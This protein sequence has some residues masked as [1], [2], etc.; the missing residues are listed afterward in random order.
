MAAETY[1]GVDGVNRK[2]K[3]IYRGVDG[4]NRDCKTVWAGIN[5][6]NRKVYQSAIGFKALG[7]TIIY[8]ETSSAQMYITV[9][10]KGRPYSRI[11]W[12]AGCNTLALVFG[13][14]LS[15]TGRRTHMHLSFNGVKSSANDAAYGVQVLQSEKDRYLEKGKYQQIYYV[16]EPNKSYT[17]DEDITFSSDKSGIAVAIACDTY[18]YD[19][20]MNTTINKIV[21]YPDQYPQGLNIIFPANYTFGDP[22]E[23]EV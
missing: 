7:A 1:R 12:A 19:M 6:V 22:L 15:F 11:S 2:I 16:H 14:T 23:V 21:L 4:V 5:G 20:Q 13:E 8:Q 10:G 18:E 17:F 9:D 3:K